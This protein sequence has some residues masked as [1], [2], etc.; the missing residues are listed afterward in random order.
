MKSNQGRTK[1]IHKLTN[2]NSVKSNIK[3]FHLDLLLKDQND[4]WL[5]LVLKTTP[6]K[7]S[8]CTRC[9]GVYDALSVRMWRQVRYSESTRTRLVRVSPSSAEP[10]P[11][12]LSVHPGLLI[13]LS[14]LMTL[15]PWPDVV[16]WQEKAPT[17]YV[18]LLQTKMKSSCCSVLS[19]A[20]PC[21]D[22]RSAYSFRQTVCTPGQINIKTCQS[23]CFNDSTMWDKEQRHVLGL[24]VSKTRFT[25]M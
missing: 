18:L 23:N 6:Q 8:S 16:S 9:F 1:T 4:L 21:W 2:K 5:H 14:V 20:P 19:T 13:V 17:G 3:K 24:G 11:R 12:L 15:S 10:D 22:N 7:A 25:P